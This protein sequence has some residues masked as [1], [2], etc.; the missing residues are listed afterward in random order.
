MFLSSLLPYHEDPHKLH[1]GC[2]APRSYF[3]PFDVSQKDVSGE[4]MYLS[5]ETSSRFKLMS[6]E[7]EFR[8][9]PS[10]TEVPDFL[11]AENPCPDRIEVPRNWQTCLGKG[12]DKPQ[13]VNVQY[14]FPVNP[15][16]VPDEDPCGLYRKTFELS[17]NDLEGKKARLVFEGVDSCFYLW[18]NRHFA[19]YRQVSQCPSEFDRTEWVH[20]HHQILAQ[21]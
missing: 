1:V 15:P 8:F 14:P 3:I 6:G 11:N 13:Y 2:L 12:Y 17:E 10:V 16:F 4:D 20:V 5:R 21:N 18:I 7:W 9:F 19:G